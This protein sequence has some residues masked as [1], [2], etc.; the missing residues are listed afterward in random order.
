MRDRFA[1]PMRT[2][3][4]YYPA[5]ITSQYI[6]NGTSM[7]PPDVQS[8]TIHEANRHTNALLEL[9]YRAVI[10]SR[11]ITNFKRFYHVTS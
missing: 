5:W 6:V 2:S 10:L 7:T 8:D 3:S 4:S 9:Q 1:G 11:S